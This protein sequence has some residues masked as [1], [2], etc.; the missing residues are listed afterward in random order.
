MAY[1]GLICTTLARCQTAELFGV[2]E[3]GLDWPVA[4]LLQH[5]RGQVTVQV[6]GRQPEIP[7]TVSGHD[8]SHG[9]IRGQVGHDT[10]GPLLQTSTP[11]Q[12]QPFAQRRHTLAAVG[13]IGDGVGVEHA[14]PCQS[15]PIDLLGQL[16]GSIENREY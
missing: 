14:N 13:V 11:L 15:Q 8:Q 2:S 10:A 1:Q 6:I 4:S 5:N 3:W 16:T 7:V 12:S 9:A